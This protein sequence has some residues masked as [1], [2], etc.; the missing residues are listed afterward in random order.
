MDL[1]C[2]EYTVVSISVI[3]PT[4]NSENTIIRALEGVLAQIQLPGEVVI[5]DDCST[6]Q[7]IPLVETMVARFEGLGIRLRLLRS[8]QNRGGAVARNRGLAEARGTA[9][10]LLDSDDLWLHDHLELAL[11]VGAGKDCVVVS[12]TRQILANGSE[13]IIPA[14]RYLN[15]CSPLDY[16]FRQNGVIQTSS[17]VL[18]GQARELRFDVSLRKHQDFDF[19]ADAYKKG[20]FIQQIWSATTEYHDYGG[21]TRVSVRKNLE[22]SRKFFLK[23]RFDL[24]KSSRRAFLARFLSLQLPENKARLRRWLFRVAVFDMEIAASIRL[25]LVARAVRGMLRP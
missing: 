6:D 22:S 13:K 15:D 14:V 21:E 23:W 18:F 1:M 11:K 17:M 3:I 5:V 19:I 25:R 8:S 20:L 24:C 4:Y 9:F 12:R 7:T 16:I 2:G 10:A